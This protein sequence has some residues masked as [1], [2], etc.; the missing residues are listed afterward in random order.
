[1][2]SIFAT[3]VCRTRRLFLLGK[4]MDY[5]HAKRAKTLCNMVIPV[6][7]T[8]VQFRNSGRRTRGSLFKYVIAR[9]EASRHYRNEH[10]QYS[11]ELAGRVGKSFNL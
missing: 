6:M 1:M 7:C 3:S 2:T 5:M 4:G 11:H 8:L 9:R 10:Y